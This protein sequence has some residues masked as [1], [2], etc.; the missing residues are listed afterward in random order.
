MKKSDL[1]ILIVEDDSAFCRI[2]TEAVKSFGFR[3]LA[4]GKVDEAI[5]LAK[6]KSIHAAIIDCVLPKMNGVEL[7]KEIRTTRFG[8]A[9]IFLM[10]G[11]LKDKSF[12]Q[13]SKESTQAIEF[14]V[15]PFDLNEL[16]SNLEK[17]LSH[18][19]E[20]KVVVDLKS[21]VAKNFQTVRQRIK[22]IEALENIK[23][24][25]LLLV[26][27]VLA[28]AKVSGQ[29]NLVSESG[30][31]YGVT[32][33]HGII[34]KVD[35]P[36]AQAGIKKMLSEKGLMDEED[37]VTINRLLENSGSNF[38][39]N[40][41][42]Q[43]LISPHMVSEIESG[44]I[45]V[46]LDQLF[47][48]KSL[49]ISYSSSEHGASE[50]LLSWENQNSYFTHILL[51][52]LPTTYLSEFYEPWDHFP[53]RLSTSFNEQDS[54]FQENDYK[55]VPNWKEILDAGPTIEELTQSSKL[56][57]D[58]VY[59]LLHTLVVRRQILFDD[60][61]KVR[62]REELEQKV[63][64]LF[65][66]TVGKSPTQIF[67]YFGVDEDM[68]VEHVERVFHDFAR[69]N[70][71][72]QIPKE[73]GEVLKNKMSQIFASVSEAYTTL[74]DTQKREVHFKNIKVKQAT[75]QMNAENIVS[76]AQQL[77]RKGQFFL[78]LGKLK[79]SYSLHAHTDT[80]LQIIFCE[81]KSA[82]Q[83]IPVAIQTSVQQKL[84]SLKAEDKRKALYLLNCAVLSKARGNIQ[85]AGEF[86]NRAIASDPN[87][88]EARR[89]LSALQA[90]VQKKK[91]EDLL[92]GDIGTVFSRFFKKKSS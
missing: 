38:V 15:K 24:W 34:V 90:A 92:T 65:E 40:A 35:A 73:A 10:S 14:F 22:V 50:S 18:H 2:L 4:V 85:D 81:L 13:E 82:P 29:L 67:E 55:T 64:T 77:I 71:P 54:I 31:I 32:L 6:I 66:N 83:P 43:S 26:L 1:S 37:E 80:L 9:P 91:D 30:N 8:K 56:E 78:A 53:I 79:E 42:T 52:R 89:E 17:A 88:L 16:K 57:K 59:R 48:E 60:Y 75:K 36:N 21:I 87:M 63:H 72:D 68:R 5:Q 19:L 20:E 51:G 84:D 7:A 86:L 46:E 45:H 61:K 3:P 44:I 28:E 69:S 74:T 27:G 33:S 23:G 39:E 49:Q 25:D 41:V 70:H 62:N 58:K 76:E 11:I 47:L 12:T